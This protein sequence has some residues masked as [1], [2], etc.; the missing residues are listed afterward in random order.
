MTYTDATIIFG[1]VAYLE[2]SRYEQDG[3]PVYFCKDPHGSPLMDGEK[4]IAVAMEP[5]EIA[6]KVGGEVVFHDEQASY[7]WIGESLG[8]AGEY[9]IA[10]GEVAPTLKQ[11]AD[12]KELFDALP[13]LAKRFFTPIGVYIL[14][15]HS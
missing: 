9:S 13:E 7:V 10:L 6:E 15:S 12:V 11:R 2:R 8:N 5:E 4:E 3:K 1:S 14:W